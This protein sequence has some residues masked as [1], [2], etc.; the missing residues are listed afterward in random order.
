[1]AW[2]ARWRW[3]NDEPATFA[4]RTTGARRTE[5]R[6]G[7]RQQKYVL[8]DQ[9][10]DLILREYDGTTE[11]IDALAT[12]LGMPRHRIKNLA[13]ELGLTCAKEPGWTEEEERYLEERAPPAEPHDDCSAPWAHKDREYNL[14]HGG[15]GMNKTQEGYTMRGLCLGLGCDHH[16]VEKWLRHNWIKGTRRQSERHG[17]PTGRFLEFHRTKTFAHLCVHIR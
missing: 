11:R 12:R 14:K 13:G 16:K 15:W 7:G 1:M 6:K 9:G 3:R 5:H 17:V 10:R 4:N 8:T 2:L